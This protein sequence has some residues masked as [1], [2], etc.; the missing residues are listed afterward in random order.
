MPGAAIEGF[1]ARLRYDYDEKRLYVRDARL[2]EILSVSPWDPW[3]RKPS[4]GVG[5]GLDTAFELG[6]RASDS[7][8]YEGHLGTGLAAEAFPGAFAYAMVA[9]ESA[10]GAGLRD[11]WR[12]GGGL[13]GG[14]AAD[15]G[16]SVRAVLEGGLSGF[17]VGDK[18]PN[19]RLR[20]GL[21]WE[22][23]RDLSVRSEFLMRGPHREGGLSAVLYR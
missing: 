18:T 12:L 11:G 8:V 13:R 5:T 16:A 10:V 4:W 1:A 22:V 20:L 3:M 9:G 6:K 15:L 7:L 19:H 14:L 17:P 2:V 23:S 21:N